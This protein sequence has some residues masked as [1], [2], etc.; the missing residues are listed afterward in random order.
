[1]TLQPICHVIDVLFRFLQFILGCDLDDVHGLICAQESKS[2]RNGPTT[3]TCLLPGDNG[4]LEPKFFGFL[5]HDEH[6]ASNSHDKVGW[7]DPARSGGSRD[8]Q[9]YR[10]CFT[11]DKFERALCQTYPPISHQLPAL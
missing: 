3:F 10:T 1:M 4:C 2:I 8:D 11:D 6:R 9:I 5:G 7:I